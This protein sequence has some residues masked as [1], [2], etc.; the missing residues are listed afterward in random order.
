[1]KNLFYYGLVVVLTLSVFL[2]ELNAQRGPINHLILVEGGNFD[3][4]GQPIRHDDVITVTLRKSIKLNPTLDEVEL[5]LT[6][7]N[8]RVRLKSKNENKVIGLSAPVQGWTLS[9]VEAPCN[10]PTP[11]YLIFEASV[12]ITI[13]M[14]PICS[15]EPINSSRPDPYS[16]QIVYELVEA[17]PNESGSYDLYHI[18]NFECAMYFFTYACFEHE[19]NLG[20]S[21]EMCTTCEGYEGGGNSNLIGN[22]NPGSPNNTLGVWQN[23]TKQNVYPNPFKNVLNWTFSLMKEGEVSIAIYSLD[24][25]QLLERRFNAPAGAS[26]LEVSTTELPA[27]VYLARIWDGIQFH[28]IKL[29]KTTD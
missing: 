20:T 5:A 28:S 8:F 22:S 3:E 17:D 29:I 10:S 25:R 9:N 23:N 21:A 11:T 4:C 13:D 24:Q 18:E 15:V 6:C 16:Q 19:P 2:S 14:A 12:D 7:P 26:T 1:M 27:G